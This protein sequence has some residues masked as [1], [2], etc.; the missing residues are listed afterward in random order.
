MIVLV[1][2]THIVIAL[3]SIVF[4]SW[5]LVRPSTRKF[6]INYGFI[7]AVLTSGTYLVLITHATMLS[8]CTSGLLYLSVIA[9]LSVVAS[10]RFAYAHES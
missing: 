8:A 9:V 4:A 10:R 7:A 6:H 3:S 1:L 5:M 2:T